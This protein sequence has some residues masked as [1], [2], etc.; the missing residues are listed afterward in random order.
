MSQ[1]VSGI[2]CRARDPSG[3]AAVEINGNRPSRTNVV[4]ESS[5]A[6][7]AREEGWPPA[8]EMPRMSMYWKGMLLV[9]WL[10]SQTLGV[11]VS[12][13]SSVADQGWPSVSGWEQVQPANHA[14]NTGMKACLDYDAELS[15]VTTE[16]LRDPVAMAR[17]TPSYD[18]CSVS[19]IRI[20]GAHR[21][22]PA[23][24]AQFLA[25]ES[26]GNAKRA[27]SSGRQGANRRAA[28]E[29]PQS[30]GG[31]TLEHT[32]AGKALEAAGGNISQWE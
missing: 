31:T 6:R 19:T 21:A 9:L 2:F 17:T 15:S 28:E 1:R 29:F 4:K 32:P 18:S 23:A 13:V 3:D 16:G 14:Y 5:R 25:A 27:F 7:A 11:A 30:T 12:A 8:P 24:K 20:A 26:A 22:P 10:L